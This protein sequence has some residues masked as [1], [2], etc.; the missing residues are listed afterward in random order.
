MRCRGKNVAFVSVD[1]R[2][3]NEGLIAINGPFGNMPLVGADMDRMNSYLPFIRKM[4]ENSEMSIRLYKF[5]SKELL[6]E[7][8]PKIMNAKPDSK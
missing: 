1:P 3:N 6:E 7:F 5:G 2:D 4:L 8:V